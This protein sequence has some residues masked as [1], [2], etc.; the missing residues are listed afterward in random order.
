LQAQEVSVID[1]SEFDAQD[2]A[3]GVTLNPNRLSA[4]A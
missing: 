3:N 2:A 4:I 1:I